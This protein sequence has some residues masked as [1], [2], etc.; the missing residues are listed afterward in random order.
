MHAVELFSKNKELGFRTQNLP[1]GGLRGAAHEN[2][3]THALTHAPTHA[4]MH[5]RG[6]QEPPGNK[7]TKGLKRNERSVL[8]LHWDVLPKV[9]C[10]SLQVISSQPS[11]PVYEVF[12]WKHTTK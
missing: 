9:N 1:G 12:P 6:N 8:S 7:E 3:R 5:P 2:L 10:G 4:Y 11:R